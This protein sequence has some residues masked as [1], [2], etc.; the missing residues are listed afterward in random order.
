MPLKWQELTADSAALVF[1][2]LFDL[3]CRHATR[4]SSRYGLAITPV[5]HVATGIN[6]GHFSKNV[7]CGLQI[8]VL[9]GIELAFENLGVGYVSDPEKHRAGGKV[10][11]FTTLEIS[12][13]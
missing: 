7:V 1:Q 11:D 3:K 12:K 6:A 2:K 4:A 5:L 10:R 9:V 13:F 8:A